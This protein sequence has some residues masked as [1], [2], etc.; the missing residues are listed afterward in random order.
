M[1][2]EGVAAILETQAGM[3]VVGEACDGAEAIDVV[4]WR[5]DRKRGLEMIQSS[6]A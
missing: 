3:T 6:A 4:Q 5:H 2:R 1:L